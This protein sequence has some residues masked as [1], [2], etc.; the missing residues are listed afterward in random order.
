MDDA[1]DEEPMVER[2]RR[3]VHPPQDYMTVRKKIVQL[4]CVALLTIKF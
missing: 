3:E 1:E 4:L 2:S